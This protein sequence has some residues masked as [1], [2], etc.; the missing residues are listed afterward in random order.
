MT[1]C[2]GPNH[3]Q[4]TIEEYRCQALKL[5][6][7]F[8]GKLDPDGDFIKLYTCFVDAFYQC[9][10]QSSCAI[11][12][13]FSPCTSELYFDQWIQEYGLPF[14]CPVNITDPVLERDLLRLQ[15]CLQVQLQA[16]S[17]FNQSLLDQIA[18]VLGIEYSVKVPT[19]NIDSVPAC[20]VIALP[21]SGINRCNP[22]GCYFQQ[23]FIICVT[24]APTPSH[25]EIFE[26]FIGQLTP[27]HVVYCVNDETPKLECETECTELIEAD[28]VTLSLENQ[29]QEC[30]EM[31]EI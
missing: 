30:T 2:C 10:V 8:S 1:Q 12:S 15:L 21:A 19:R 11:S 27:C 23:A 6:P 20:D 26:C 7:D 14:R 4:M 17:V 31:I 22:N 3:C 9:V 5:L 18:D 28:C 24:C 25:I 29:D 16:G 13:E